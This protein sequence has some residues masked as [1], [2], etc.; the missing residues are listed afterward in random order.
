[1]GDDVPPKVRNAL[2]GLIE[3]LI[4]ER[5]NDDSSLVDRRAAASKWAKDLFIGYAS[6]CPNRTTI[7]EMTG[8][9]SLGMWRTSGV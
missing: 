3:T 5:E 8:Q 7:D 2:P 4:P 9:V 6:F 1:M